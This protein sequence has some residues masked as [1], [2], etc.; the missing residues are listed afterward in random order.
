MSGFPVSMKKLV[1]E[2]ARMPGIGP[3]SAQ[4]LAFY[5]LRSPRAAAQTL[6]DAIIKV[7]ET[8]KF[9]KICN[10][11][12]DE[13]VCDICQSPSRDK[14]LLCV[15]EEP[16]DIMPIERSG[17]FNGLYHVLL[18]SLSPLDGIGPS[19]LKIEELLGR[20]KKER[21]KE[22][23][24]ATDFNTEGEA[25]SLYLQRV[26]KSSGVRMTRVAYGIPVGGDIEY[27]DQA[28]LIKAF[29]GRRTIG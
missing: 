28:T 27:A 21:F 13:E 2:F 23:I 3:K 19:D 16:N 17:N 15:V 1:E 10:N 9:C 7:K 29:E 11:L 14:S 8:V 20:V 6:A 4:R 12:S 25:T 5:V 22:I 18:G 26:L 24:V